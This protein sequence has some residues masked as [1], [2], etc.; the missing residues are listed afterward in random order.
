MA[1]SGAIA[2]KLVYPKQNV[3][4]VTS[5]NGFMAHYP[6]LEPV[7]W[8][9]TPFVT[10]ICNPGGWH[11][12]FVEISKSMGFTGYRVTSSDGLIATLK[13]ALAQDTPAI[14]DCP[15]DCRDYG[16]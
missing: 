5:I 8:L 2:A 16:A 12:N 7:R 1:I 11:P 6:E 4:T 10:L 14:I 15:V 9:K 3:V 13:T